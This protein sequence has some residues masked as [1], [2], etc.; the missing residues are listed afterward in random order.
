MKPCG[1]GLR[2]GGVL[3][4]VEKHWEA[5]SSSVCM[6]CSGAMAKVLGGIP[7]LR[8]RTTYDGKVK[9]EVKQQCLIKYLENY[10]N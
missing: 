9:R 2:F 1:K 3:K 8:R 6:T 4:V 7:I 10:S 5:G